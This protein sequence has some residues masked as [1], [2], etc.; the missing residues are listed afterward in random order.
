VGRRWSNPQKLCP[1]TTPTTPS[2]PR[3]WTRSLCPCWTQTIP[4]ISSCRMTL[5]SVAPCSCSPKSAGSQEQHKT[6]KRCESGSNRPL[7]ASIPDQLMWSATSQS[8]SGKRISGEEFGWGCCFWPG[9]LFLPPPSSQ[10]RL[11]VGDFFSPQ[12]PHCW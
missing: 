1:T 6:C 7:F 9:W 2:P 3:K 10:G 11:G 12:P 4:P 5:S 8:H